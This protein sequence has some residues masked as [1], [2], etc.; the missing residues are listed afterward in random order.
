MIRFPKVPS[1]PASTPLSFPVPEMPR[2]TPEHRGQRGA[3]GGVVLGMARVGWRRW[4]PTPGG[5]KGE[6]LSRT[7]PGNNHYLSSP[8]GMLALDC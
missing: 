5:V 1:T 2:V 7:L 3:L 4:T 6:G 8:W